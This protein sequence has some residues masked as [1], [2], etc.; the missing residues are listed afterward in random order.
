MSETIEVS[1]II[2]N[3]R[4]KELTKACVESLQAKTE[5]IGYEIILVDNDSGDGSYEYFEKELSGI[6]L[7]RS[8]TNLGFGKANNLAVKDATGK[9]LFFLNPDTVVKNNALVM[10]KASF[11]SGGSDLGVLG[12]YLSD[13]HGN[14]IHSHAHFKKPFSQM[15]RKYRKLFK[16]MFFLDLL[17][18]KKEETPKPVVSSPEMSDVDYVTGADMFIPRAL[19]EEAGGF[20]P[21]FFMYYE[22]TELQK[23]LQKMGYRRA[24]VGGPQIVHY[25]SQS[26]QS[27]SSNTKR[28]MYYVSETKFMAKAYGKGIGTVYKVFYLLNILLGTL[29]DLYRREYSIKENYLLMQNLWMGTYKL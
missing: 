4:T 14:A 8:T 23:R 24:I 19:F 21:D 2:V 10:L 12:V 15:K 9:Y 3:Y 16:K 29:V 17:F 1:V 11:E 25:V 13:Q 26:L 22:E 5:G 28:I 20:D 18:R 7:I 27:S 6:T